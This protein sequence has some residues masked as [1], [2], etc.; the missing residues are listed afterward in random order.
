MDLVWYR[1]KTKSVDDVRPLID[2]KDIQMPYWCTGYAGDDSYATIVCFLPKG[3]D[4]YKYWDD[5]YD[6]AS[7][8][9]DGITYTDR[10]P[11]PSWILTERQKLLEYMDNPVET[12]ARNSMGCSENWY[13]PYYA[14]KETF[15]KEKIENM[16]DSEIE[17]L[18]EL[19]NEIGLAL[20]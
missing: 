19:A 8:E 3:E 2:M 12:K 15:S 14:I 1:F 20:Y 7:D 5:A 16:S 4:L 11:K 9:R 6:I 10:F 18:V 17:N 13:N